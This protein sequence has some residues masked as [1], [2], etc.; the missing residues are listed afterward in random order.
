MSH[1]EIWIALFGM[2]AVTIVTRAFFLMV[3]ERVSVPDRI[4]RALRYAPPAALAAIILPDLMTWEGELMFSPD[5]YKLIAG[6]VAGAFYIVTRRMLA[7]IGVGMA[8]YTAL[9]LVL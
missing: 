7:M 4:Q 3:G 9:R 6:V 5:N 2:A 8:V 1:L